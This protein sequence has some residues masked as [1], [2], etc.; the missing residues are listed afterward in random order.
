MVESNRIEVLKTYKLFI[1]GQ[2]PRSESGHSYE[3][4]SAKGKFLANPALAS[5]KDLRDAVVAAR[6][7]QNGWSAATAYNRGQILYRVAEVL[8]VRKEDL[9]ASLVAES[10]M[11]QVMA[12]KNVL[13]GIDYW[14]WAAGWS[15]KIASTLGSTNPVAGPFYNFTVPESLGV[16]ALFPQANSGFLGLSACLASSIVSGNTA[17][18]IANEKSP[19]TAIALAE[20]LAVSDLPA[21]VVNILTGKASE[22][23]D[24]VAS[25]MEIDGVEASGLSKSSLM[26]LRVKGAQNFKRIASFKPSKDFKE[27]ERLTAFLEYKTVWHTVG[28]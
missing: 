21:G 18:V 8:E 25:H 13:A 20:S 1:N 27:V 14:V 24:W 22:L 19:L 3:L 7:A 10:G 16:I 9:I 17:I 6:N 28:Y 23:E 11:T 4:K 2:F 12:R 26:N 15:D 5:R